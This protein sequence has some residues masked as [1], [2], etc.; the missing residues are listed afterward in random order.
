MT[1]AEMLVAVES[2][3]VV[4]LKGSSVSV[5]G[6]SYTPADLN[7]LYKMRKDLQTKIAQAAETSRTVSYADMSGQ[8][9]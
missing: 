1:D 9:D 4:A 7:L 3:I 5:D 2:A 6:Q 8:W